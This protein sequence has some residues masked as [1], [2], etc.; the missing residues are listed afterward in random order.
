MTAIK[1]HVDMQA[2]LALRLVHETKQ[3][4][5][6]ET[7][8][9]YTTEIADSTEAW[10]RTIY[11]K[12]TVPLYSTL[13]IPRQ[14]L[15]FPD[16]HSHTIIIILLLLYISYVHTAPIYIHTQYVIQML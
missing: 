14:T 6:I 5:G 2:L 11:E 15:I 12:C 1:S 3:L 7:S 10:N 8:Y 13:H 9:T 4:W 16:A